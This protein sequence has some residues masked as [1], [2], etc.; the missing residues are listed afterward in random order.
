MT[1]SQLQVFAKV[2]ETGSFTKAG[3]A[4]NMT[5]SAVSHAMASIESEL[6]VPL[7]IRDR[8]QG[9]ML[10]DFGE[11]ILKSVREILKHMTQIEHAAMAEKGLDAG[12]IRIG[13]FPSATARLLPKIISRF[14]QQYPRVEI[15][16]FDG[17]DKEVLSWL[18][19]RVIDVGFVA[20]LG[21]NDNFIPLTK[22]KMVLALPKNHSFGDS[23]SFSVESFSDAPFIMS[24]GGCE[25]FI[26]EIFAHA[27]LSPSVQFE[28]RDMSTILSMVQEG[29]GI[30][31]VPELALPDTLPGIEIRDLKPTY[32]RHLGLQC[33]YLDEALPAVRAFISMGQSL[34]HGE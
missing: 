12:T 11:R 8:K 21:R 23:A 14:K 32:L 20:Q 2:V 10:S 3:E 9:I 34:F 19:D 17:D 4:L 7:I 26:R 31:I 13:S 29:L 5:Q 33:P 27:G 24:K 30:T 15:V 16:L 22:D 18:N 25:P 28:V 6:G 1:F